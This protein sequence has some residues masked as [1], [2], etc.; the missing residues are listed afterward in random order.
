MKDSVLVDNRTSSCEL[1]LFWHCVYR[2]A[3]PS[4]LSVAE[5]WKWEMSAKHVN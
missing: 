5:K 3:K 4:F 1:H 2:S